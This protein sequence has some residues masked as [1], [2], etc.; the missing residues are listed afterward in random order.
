[1]TYTNAQRK[2]TAAFCGLVLSSA[3]LV[4]VTAPAYATSSASAPSS[5]VIAKTVS[6]D[7][8]V[9]PAKPPIVTMQ[10]SVPAMPSA[11]AT[12]AKWEQWASEQRSAAEHTP[13]A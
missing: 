6:N 9:T 2:I 13:V 8:T 10:G 1:M 12:M 7:T 11:G 4:S 3:M 5:P